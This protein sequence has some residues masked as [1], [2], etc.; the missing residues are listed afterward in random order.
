VNEGAIADADSY[1]RPFDQVGFYGGA[2]NAVWGTEA[3]TNPELRVRG[4]ILHL[5]H[6]FE[7]GVEGRAIA[8]FAT[9]TSFTQIVGVPMALH[10]GRYVRF[11]FGAYSHF[12]FRGQP[13]GVL[14]TFEFPAAFWFQVHE[15]VFL[16]PM[17]GFRYYSE[18]VY[19]SGLANVDVNLGFGV[20]VSL[21]RFADLK[22]QLYF[23]RVDDAPHYVGGGVAVGFYFH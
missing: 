1:A 9:G 11:D 21:A 10:L 12:T 19:A 13:A 16:G 15:R 22:M 17:F 3:V 14:A 5:K 6:I 20:G 2:T 7:L 8:P 18:N 23:P 4:R